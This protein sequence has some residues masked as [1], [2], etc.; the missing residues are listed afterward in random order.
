MPYRDLG[1]RI[2]IVMKALD[3]KPGATATT[4]VSGTRKQVTILGW[5]N[6]RVN[7]VVRVRATGNQIYRSPRQ[8][9]LI[10][11]LPSELAVT[12][13]APGQVIDAGDVVITTTL[14]RLG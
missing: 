6:D 4:V 13:S 12:S 11:R 14:H 7:V 8:L 9:T 10:T 2:V 3:I 5:S 1:H